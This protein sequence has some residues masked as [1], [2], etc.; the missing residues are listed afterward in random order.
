VTTEAIEAKAVAIQASEELVIKTQDLEESLLHNQTL[1]C[2]LQAAMK[3]IEAAKASEVF[4]HTEVYFYFTMFLI[5]KKKRK[6]KDADNEI[7]T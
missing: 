7:C 5:L 4:A 3:E 1:E 2:R 6:K